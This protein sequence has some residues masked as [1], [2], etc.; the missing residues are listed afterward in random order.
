M[1]R[2]TIDEIQG[3]SQLTPAQREAIYAALDG[4]GGNVDFSVRP[5]M[6][7]RP[8][9]PSTSSQIQDAAMSYAQK[10][11]IKYAG[12]QAAGALGLGGTGTTAA[13][14]AGTAAGTGTAATAGTG[15][16]LGSMGLAGLGAGAG[17]AAGAYLTGRGAY[18]MLSGKDQRGT[19]EFASNLVKDPTSMQ[20]LS[21]AG[22]A[23][24]TMG[25]SELVNLAGF[26]GFGGKKS[27]DQ[28][29]RDSIRSILKQ[30]GVANDDLMATLAD[31]SQ[32]SLGKQGKFQNVGENIDG[33]KERASYDVDFSNPLAKNA[34]GAVDP[35]AKKFLGP[36]ATQ[37]QLSDFTGLIVNAATSNAASQDDVNKN[38]AAMFG[39]QSMPVPQASGGGGQRRP[40]TPKKREEAV[41]MIAM[42]SWVNSENRKD[43]PL[44]VGGRVV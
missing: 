37:K 8:Q 7:N 29:G 35:Y 16:G 32:F 30:N 31:G 3:F 27:K 14:G 26:K 36:K 1:A 9:S 39:A 23:M 12:K 5:N 44:S 33:K 13:S 10:E 40:S 20:N 42:P 41:R 2:G 24:T 19:G 25:M 17:I 43:A 18:N 21:R 6:L 22:L 28:L 4:R 38:I 15:V 34:I 11:G